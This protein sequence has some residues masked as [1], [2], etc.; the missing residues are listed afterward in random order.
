MERV[1]L[2]FLFVLQLAL[3]LDIKLWLLPLFFVS[4]IFL[5]NVTHDDYSFLVGLSLQMT[6]STFMCSVASTILPLVCDITQA[7]ISWNLV[8]FKDPTGPRTCASDTKL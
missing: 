6:D 8:H 1:L 7:S 3:L 4:F 2:I 5:A